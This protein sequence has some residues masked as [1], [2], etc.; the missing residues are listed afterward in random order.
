[1]LAEELDT[2]TG[3]LLGNFPQAFSHLGLVLAAQA[4]ADAGSGDARR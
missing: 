4:I 1:L 2:S 3:E